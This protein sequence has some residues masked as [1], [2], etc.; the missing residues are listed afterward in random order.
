M[1]IAQTNVQLYNQLR[2]QNRPVADLVTIHRAYEF[3]TT[4]YT[5]YFSRD[6]K[7]FIAH[8]VGVA[9][10]LAEIEQPAEIVA[11]GLLHNVYAN[12]DFGDGGR[13][14]TPARR[15]LVRAGVGDR[16]E[17]LIARFPSV[18][19]QG[20]ARDGALRAAS[21]RDDDERRLI[22]VDL[23]DLLE[24][25]VD[26]GVLYLDREDRHLR[27]LGAVEE[28]VALAGEL[29]EPRLAEML[30][31]AFAAAAI[32]SGEVPAEL[33]STAR[34]HLI[35]PRSYRRRA[36]IR[37]RLTSRRLRSTAR[38]RTRIHGLLGSS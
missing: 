26:L 27:Q 36:S 5:G 29:G 33:R 14:V 13:G 2:R 31:T 30:S 23:A 21:D 19:M 1:Q 8:C 16:V 37:L 4:L 11:M 20:R 6:G 3:M 18:R 32:H 35:V 7:P 9:S 25:Y 28:V 34:P 22:V 24:K 12:A 10:I 15:R 17:G 38:V